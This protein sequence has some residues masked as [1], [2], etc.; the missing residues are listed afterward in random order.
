MS[1]MATNL[2]RINLEKIFINVLL[3][4]ETFSL[5]LLL[6]NKNSCLTVWIAFLKEVILAF[7]KFHTRRWY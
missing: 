4:I 7:L 2:F 1:S 5:T 6:K 3:K